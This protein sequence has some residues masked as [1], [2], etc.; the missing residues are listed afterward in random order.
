VDAKAGA[1]Y[2]GYGGPQSAV[3][4]IENCT[5]LSSGHGI[6][7][8]QSTPVIVKGSRI[9]GT[10]TK[11]Y[12][13]Y[14]PYLRNP[15]LKFIDNE[16]FIPKEAYHDSNDPCHQISLLQNL[17][18]SSENHVSTDLI[19]LGAEHFATTYTTSI[20][21]NDHYDSGAA[22]RPACNSSFDTSMPYSQN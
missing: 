7:N 20:V 2:P 9:V 18:L 19:P 13:T 17:S 14:I 6:V 10:H 22:F 15:Q 4:T 3:T 12:S 11:P 21:L 1:I 16:I 8:D 5:I